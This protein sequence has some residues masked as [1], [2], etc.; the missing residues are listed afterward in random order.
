MSRADELSDMITPLVAESSYRLWNLGITK[1]SKRSIVTVTLDK[2]GGA[3][4][5]EMAKISKKIAVLI[6]EHPSFENEYHLFAKE[7]PLSL[8]IK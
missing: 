7:L 2:D 5:D 6:D 8:S 1:A 3:N 4:L